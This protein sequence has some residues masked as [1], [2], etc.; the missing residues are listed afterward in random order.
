MVRSDGALLQLSNNAIPEPS[1]IALLGAGAAL[2]LRRRA[3][4]R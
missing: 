2:L 1:A 4:R 3:W